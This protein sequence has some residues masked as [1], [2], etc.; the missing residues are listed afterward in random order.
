M[1]EKDRREFRALYRI[2]LEESYAED[3]RKEEAANAE[4]AASRED[5]DNWNRINAM[6]NYEE[7]EDAEE[8]N[9]LSRNPSERAGR[10]GTAPGRRTTA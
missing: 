6:T 8:D 10:M 9:T 7:E 2:L 4:E 1:T 5:E 3:T